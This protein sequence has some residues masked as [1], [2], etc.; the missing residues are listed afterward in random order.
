MTNFK[1]QFAISLR[2]FHRLA[3]GYKDKFETTSEHCD[4]FHQAASDLI[5]NGL[6]SNAPFAVSRFGHSEL[7]AILTY[8]HINENDSFWKKILLFARGEKV[9]PWWSENTIK[10]ITHNAGLFPK[11]IQVI[12]KF[13]RLILEDM[14]QID[15]LGSWLGGESWIKPMLT[16]TKFIR[17]HDFYHF[18]HEEPWT[19]GLGEKKVLVIHPFSKSILNQYKIKNKIFSGTHTLPNFVLS[20]YT[21]V[22]S[23]AGNNPEGFNDWFEALDSM[24]ADVSKMHFDVAVIGCG[25]YGMPLAAFIKR[26]LKKKA[27]HLGGNTQILFGIKGTRWENDPNFSHIF[28]SYWIKPLDEET[29]SG[30]MTID[31]NCYW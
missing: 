25:A 12:E 31:S 26:D 9:E 7:R 4:Y 18:L 24:K 28:N 29:P 2:R 5:R 1:K 17:F 30:H 23:I 15:V 8:L 27:I 22:Q 21:S 11:K 3:L 13:C 6:E 20:T 19:L 16:K 10:L 14:Q